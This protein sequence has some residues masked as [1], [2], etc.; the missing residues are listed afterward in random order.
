MIL[1]DHVL[2]AIDN[3]VA[4][5]LEKRPLT[6]YGCLI[7]SEISIFT[8]AQAKIRVLCR[9]RGTAG[10]RVMSSVKAGGKPVTQ[11][12]KTKAA[13][14]VDAKAGPAWIE[15]RSFPA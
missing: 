8:A 3:L 5:C 6:I 7:E 14:P 2:I 1:I 15:I 4:R 9:R 12:P 10:E 11:K 13:K